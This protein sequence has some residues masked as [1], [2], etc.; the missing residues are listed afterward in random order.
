MTAGAITVRVH[1]RIKMQAAGRMGEA[2]TQV[3]RNINFRSFLFHIL[4][5]ERIGR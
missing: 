2:S 4:M 1:G 3:L 5:T